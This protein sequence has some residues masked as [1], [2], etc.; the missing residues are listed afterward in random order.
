MKSLEIS[1]LV[2]SDEIGHI[3]ARRR[4]TELIFYDCRFDISS[5]DID[6]LC[7]YINNSPTIVRVAYARCGGSKILPA[8]LASCANL[9]TFD[10]ERIGVKDIVD[11]WALFKAVERNRSLKRFLYREYSENEDEIYDYMRDLMACGTLEEIQFIKWG[12][13]SRHFCD[14]AYGISMSSTIK[15]LC[16][17]MSVSESIQN[18]FMDIIGKRHPSFRDISFAR[19]ANY[20]NGP[21]RA[22]WK[23]IDL[24]TVLCA[25]RALGKISPIVVLH[26][27]LIRLL[28]E[29]FL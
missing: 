29:H 5:A 17:S 22:K 12:M 8:R 25:P 15:I 21:L 3:C 19:P 18:Q 11:N 4:L 23:K 9:K 13:N 14:L 7:E 1:R 6:R 26:F 27:D 10:Y 24:L 16:L 2:D 28:V 20:I